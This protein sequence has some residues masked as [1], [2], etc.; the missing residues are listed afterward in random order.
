MNTH[1]Y[2][3][4]LI[5]LVFATSCTAENEVSTASSNQTA[6]TTVLQSRTQVSETTVTPTQTAVAAATATATATQTLVAEVTPT[7]TPVATVTATQTPVATVTATTSPSTSQSADNSTGLTAAEIR[8]Y[9]SKIQEDPSICRTATGKLALVCNM[10]ED[11]SDGNDQSHR[12]RRPERSSAPTVVPAVDPNNPPRVAT[13]NFVD[14]DPYIAISKIRSAYGHNY[15]AGD[16]EYDPTGKSCRSMKH[17][18]DAYT[19]EQRWSGNFGSYDTRGN[20][21]FYAPADGTL[22]DIMI[23]PSDVGMEYQFTIMSSE[24][25]KISFVF[26]HVDLLKDLRD[27]GPVASGQ[28][29]GYIAR[30][31]GQAEIATYVSTGMGTAEYISFFDV[32]S[33]DVFAEYQARGIIDRDQMSITQEQR[34]ANPIACTLGDGKGG[35]FVATGD[36]EAFDRWQFGSDNWVNMRSR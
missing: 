33:D 11:S 5:L 10:D 23:Q 15:S 18:F 12:S 35:K 6:D 4:V 20:V 17:Y 34:D 3:I 13:N 36:P 9:A 31:N 29:L 14:L 8:T 2:L 19:F 16:P 7:Q 21:K 24:S 32:M 25:S 22:M 28:H 26:H 30:F 1:K 27:G